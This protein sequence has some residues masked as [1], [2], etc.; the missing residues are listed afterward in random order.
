MMK[1]YVFILVLMVMPFMGYSQFSLSGKVTDQET[2]EKIVGAT[3][4]IVNTFI[5]AY[6]DYD[7]NYVFK[8]IS[9][10]EIELKVTCIGYQE[11]KRKVNITHDTKVDFSLHLNVF[12]VDEFTVESTRVTDKSGMAYTNID[13]SKIEEN[14][15][16]QDI[17]YVLKL[18]PSVVETS[19][20]GTGV[21]YTYLRIRGSDATRINVTINGIPVNDAEDHGVYWVDMPDLIG[22]VDNIQIQ[23]GVGTSTNGAGAFGATIN[24]QT[25]ALDTL[26]HAESNATYGSYKTW[27]NNLSFGTGLIN[28]KWDFE[29][30]LSKITSDGY[31]DR[32]SSDF[33]SFFVSGGYYGKKSCL[34]LNVFSGIEKTYQAWN[35]VPQDTLATN[36]T[37]NVYTYSNE[38]DNYQLDNFQLLYSA[39]LSQRWNVNAA[40]HYTHGFGYYEQY[41]DA[42]NPYNPQNPDPSSQLFSTY[43]LINVIIGNDT[44]TGTNMIRQLWLDNQF[45]GTTFSINYND[46]KKFQFTFGGGANRYNGDHYTKIVWA[47][48]ASN[49]NSIDKYDD[50]TS[51]KK[52]ANIYAKAYY[53]IT[54]KLNLFADIQFRNINYT[55]LGFDVNYNNVAQSAS[56][57]FF[58]P[59]AGINYNIS[60]DK[61]LYASYSSGNR[62]PVRD[63]YVQS[64][65]QSRPLP[66][67]L[68]DLE[69]GYK[70]QT[71]S[72]SFGA[73]V[74]YMN[75]KNQLAITG[76]LNDVGAYI[77]QNIPKSYREGIELEAA[78][79]ICKALDLLANASFSQNKIPGHNEYIDAYDSI[80]NSLGQDTIHTPTSTIAFSPSIV[81][82][83]ILT[84]HPFKNLSVSY[85]AKYV[86][87]QFLD[88]TSNPERVISSYETNDFRIKYSIKIAPVKELALSFAVIN[89]TNN[90]Y[91]SNGWT[92][93]Y[94]QGGTII[95]SNNYF[96]QAPRNYFASVSLKF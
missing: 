35:G 48:Y 7:G 85:V 47:Q 28:G 59:K 93:S 38:T 50:N 13:K 81:S 68:Y 90:L 82:S 46:N 86:S 56:L 95:T 6:T 88:N 10:G 57:I 44:I 52:D 23:R 55:F 12:L 39:Q 29:G 19:D 76:Q 18:T 36:R 30:R 8:N 43:G 78:V 49:S 87:Q 74:Y 16:G 79:K 37:Y 32:A 70:Q 92:Y 67:T 24:M 3:V 54:K 41:I 72:L 60:N 58:N 14:N 27:K 40:L 64:T 51:V 63:D 75:Y 22:S 94:M 34:K 1:N 80:G 4:L 2:G 17:P 65:P 21:G 71:K 9:E 15:I 26:A 61:R 91:V 53:D 45:Y 77:D 84:W 25:N 89:F 69:A 5:G 73:N 42:D 31:I 83:G 96:P 66:E 11:Q 62:E 20:G 33:K